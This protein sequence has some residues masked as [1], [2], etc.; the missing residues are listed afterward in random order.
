MLKLKFNDNRQEPIWIVEKN[1][2][3]GCADD[4]H[5]II[6]D[7]SVSPKHAKITCTN[8]TYLLKDLNSEHGTMVNNNVIKQHAIACHDT[9]KFG[10]VELSIVDP[11]TEVRDYEWSLIASSSFLTGQEFPIL[12][13]NDNSIIVGRAKRCDIAFA[14][15]LLSKEHARF[16]PTKE[17]LLVEDLG[18]GNGVFVND[19]RVLKAHLQSGDKVRLDVYSFRIFGPGISMPR[20]AIALTKSLAQKSRTLSE[21]PTETPKQWIT[22]PTSPGNRSDATTSTSHS[23]KH[24]I[25]I[26]LFSLVMVGLLLGLTA[27]LFF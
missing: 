2:T 27:Y 21:E 16:T 23:A 9:L 17:G 15:T 4:N 18:S 20:S 13:K 3:I 25:M 5:L 8:Q 10:D 7:A 24:P 6:H 26:F 22:R 1:F 14:G 12:A 11:A 19:E